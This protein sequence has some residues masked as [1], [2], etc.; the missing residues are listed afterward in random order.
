MHFGLGAAVSADLEIAWPSG[1]RE[2]VKSV[3]ADQLITIKEGAGVTG[4]ERFAR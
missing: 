4:R 2:A 1:A 3:A